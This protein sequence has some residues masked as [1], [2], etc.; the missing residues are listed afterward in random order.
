MTLV[1][2]WLDTCRLID[3]SV[4]TDLCCM[5]F[6]FVLLLCFYNGLIS[7]YIQYVPLQVVRSDWSQLE[8]SSV[9]STSFMHSELS[10]SNTFTC[11]LV[12]HLRLLMPASSPSLTWYPEQQ[13]VYC[14]STKTSGPLWCVKR[15]KQ[16]LHLVLHPTCLFLCSEQ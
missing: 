10:I 16:I 2:Y 3:K 7:C 14:L 12:S 9:S 6:V 11:F 13:S 1:A 4:L 5:Q 15:K 8:F